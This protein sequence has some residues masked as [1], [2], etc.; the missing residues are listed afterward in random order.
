MY[1]FWGEGD[2]E[3]K[4]SLYSC[5]NVENVEP[6]LTVSGGIWKY[7]DTYQDGDPASVY[8]NMR[9][10]GSRNAHVASDFETDD[11]RD[12]LPTTDQFLR[13]L[14]KYATHHQLNR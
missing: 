10:N 6:P 4:Y 13:Y 3:K 1:S 7:N 2:H 12:E 5:G 14:L 11:D 8:E 9:M